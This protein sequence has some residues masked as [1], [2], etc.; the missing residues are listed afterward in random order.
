MSAKVQEETPVLVEQKIGEGGDRG[1]SV[2]GLE[3]EQQQMSL[4]EGI[5]QA[6]LIE[7]NVKFVKHHLMTAWELEYDVASKERKA[8]MITV[9]MEEEE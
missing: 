8:E 4:E 5:S 7:S 3:R 2:K 6:L 9:K 1:T